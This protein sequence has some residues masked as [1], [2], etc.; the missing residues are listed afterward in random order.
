[1]EFKKFLQK[2]DVEVLTELNLHIPYDNYATHKTP[3]AKNWL[4]AHP[5]FHIHFTPIGSSWLNQVERWFAHL[6]QQLLQRSVHKNIQAV[7]ADIRAWAKR[8]NENPKPSIWTK[9]ADQILESIARL[10]KR[11]IGAGHQTY[12][13]VGGS[14]FMGNSACCGSGQCPV[15]RLRDPTASSIHR[16]ELN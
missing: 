11:N 6:T 15:T 16:I 14:R 4:S 8:W 10:M 2:I 13:P 5:R 1:M 7:E 9:T 3:K 12:R